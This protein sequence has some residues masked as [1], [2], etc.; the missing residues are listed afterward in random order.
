MNTINALEKVLLP[1]G[2]K[3]IN[4]NDPSGPV[5]GKVVQDNICLRVYTYCDKDGVKPSVQPFLLKFVTKNGNKI[6]KI[7]S[8]RRIHTHHFDTDV[9]Q[10]MLGEALDDWEMQLNQED[11]TCN[12]CEGS[13]IYCWTSKNNNPCSGQCNRCGGKGYQDFNDRRKNY[14][15]DR[16]AEEM[17]SQGA[18]DDG[19]V[20]ADWIPHWVPDPDNLENPKFREKARNKKRDFK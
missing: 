10:K 20:Y 18:D 15:Y 9:W 13:G 11:V 1:R 17:T 5:Y 12:K 6:E 4:L 8:E 3:L 14:Y 7:G 19:E 2:F 16:H